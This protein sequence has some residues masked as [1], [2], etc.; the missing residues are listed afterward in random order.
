MWSCGGPSCEVVQ[1][2][3][4]YWKAFVDKI[5]EK[6][7]TKGQIQLPEGG[8]R[9]RSEAIIRISGLVGGLLMI[10]GSKYFA[11]FLQGAG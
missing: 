11:D 4:E 1:G 7:R 5:T 6:N 8:T 2:S 3:L 9:C 10:L